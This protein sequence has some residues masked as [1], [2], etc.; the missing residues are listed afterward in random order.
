MYHRYSHIYT[1]TIHCSDFALST[2]NNA[3]KHIHDLLMPQTKPRVNTDKQQPEKP[4][5][6]VFSCD[7]FYIQILSQRK[8]SR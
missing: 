7:W 8:V 2:K 5:S 4:H 6:T 3:T 1:D